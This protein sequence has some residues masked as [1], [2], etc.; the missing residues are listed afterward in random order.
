L[1]ECA[2][3]SRQRRRVPLRQRV[4]GALDTLP[5]RL[6]SPLL[7]PA[8]RGGYIELGKFRGRK[9]TPALRAVG[10][11][12]R[13]IYDMRHT[14]ATWSLAAG[15]SLFALSRRMGTSLQMIDQTYG[16][17]A[18]DAEEQERTL[19]DAHDSRSRAVEGGGR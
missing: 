19:L 5:P 13:R 18:P 11:P 3:T 14:Y 4:L 15:V 7:F 2:K 9:W 17:L 1:K 6:D 16:H 8:A 10:I 12:H